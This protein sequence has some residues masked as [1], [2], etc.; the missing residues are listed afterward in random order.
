MR[1]VSSALVALL[2]LAAPYPA[3]AATGDHDGDGRSDVF[4]RNGTTGANAI[5]KSGDASTQQLTAGVTSRH[6]NVVGTGDF[7][8]DGRSD[9]FWRNDTTGANAIWKSGNAATPQAVA[10]VTN[11]SWQVVGVGDFDGD[12]KSDVLWRNTATGAN[13]IWKSG[14]AA[15]LLAVAGVSNRS[16][17]VVGIGDFDG[18]GR[19]DAFWRNTGTG[20]NVIWKSGNAA[21]RQSASS[22]TDLDWKVV[23]VN[24]FD[25]DGRRDVFWRNTTTGANVI[26]KSGNAATRQAVT[27][28]TNPNWQ[29]V[30]SGDYDGDGKA[31]VFWRNLATGV[32]VIWK[33]ASA[34][35]TQPVA[36]VANF[37]WVVVPHEGQTI[38]PTLS[39]ADVLIIEGN[40]GTR[41][42][43]FT[44]RLS[45][46]SAAPV[47]YSIDAHDD[48]VDRTATAGSDY[49]ARNLTGQLI[50]AGA[51]SATFTVTINGDAEAEANETFQVVV[52]EA[53]GA[54]CCAQATGTILNDDANVLWISDARVFEGNSGTTPMTFTIRLSRPSSSA[55]TYDITTADY[56]PGVFNATAGIDY[57]AKSQLHQSIPAGATSSTFTVSIIGDLVYEPIGEIFHV[58]VSNVVGALVVDGQADGDIVDDEPPIIP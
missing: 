36:S 40:S 46:A 33:S 21:T 24:D 44:V 56:P 54:T 5:W 39:I 26:W 50:A 45:Q 13:T 1:A 41:Q 7:D 8:G 48:D 28:V 57:L 16:W 55:V 30:A 14:N 58:N 4:W 49:V 12:G 9:V 53:T 22:V 47:V 10:G 51:T 25:G 19:S 27:G 18:D 32:N 11:L 35:T 31:D 20:A 23:G 17:E 34:S 37:A 42:A 3:R 29:V 38:S 52:Y 2:L 15:T 43:R 6:W